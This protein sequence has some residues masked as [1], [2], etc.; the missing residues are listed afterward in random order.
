MIVPPHDD[1]HADLFLFFRGWLK[2]SSSVAAVFPL[3][4]PFT[5]TCLHVVLITLRAW[6]FLH[7]WWTLG[8][9][10]VAP[11]WRCMPKN[12]SRGSCDIFSL[13]KNST[14][15]TLANKYFTKSM[16]ER[17]AQESGHIRT[18]CTHYIPVILIPKRVSLLISILF[19]CAAVKLGRFITARS[20]SSIYFKNVFSSHWNKV[21]F[22]HA[23]IDLYSSHPTW[24]HLLID[25][26]VE[27]FCVCVSQC[28]SWTHSAG[29]KIC[30]SVTQTWWSLWHHLDLSTSVH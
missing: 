24:R 5:L 1:P 17:A 10:L 9:S 25:M 14:P 28:T 26:A 4:L 29:Q 2:F 27:I 21:N 12:F 16:N 18:Q 20:Q 19:F 3:V 15:G 23:C 6:V 7:A 11:L 8:F 22:K 13:K 30:Q